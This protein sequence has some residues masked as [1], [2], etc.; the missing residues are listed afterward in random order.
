MIFGRDVIALGH[1][2]R[3]VHHLEEHAVDAEPD[4]IFFS[5]G[6]MWMSLAPPLIAVWMM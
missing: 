3:R 6:S 1:A 2:R 5:A 4:L